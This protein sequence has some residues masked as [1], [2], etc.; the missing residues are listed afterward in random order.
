MGCILAYEVIA[1]LANLGPSSS[2]LPF[3]GLNFASS[4]NQANT[5]DVST[6]ELETGKARGRADLVFE[7]DFRLASSAVTYYSSLVRELI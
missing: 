3:D 6:R 5:S 7:F 4:H 1:E 2:Y